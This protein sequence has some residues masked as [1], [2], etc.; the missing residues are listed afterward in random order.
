MKSIFLFT[1]A[2][3][4][5]LSLV[6]PVQSQTPIISAPSGWPVGGL[7]P[8]GVNAATGYSKPAAVWANNLN[9]Y[10][11]AYR[12]SLNEIIVTRVSPSGAVTGSFTAA[13]ARNYYSRGDPRVAYSTVYQDL[14]VVWE[15]VDP[16]T[17]YSNIRGSLDQ[18]G[19]SP[20]FQYSHLHRRAGR[21]M[22]PPFSGLFSG[23]G[24]VPG[25][26]AARVRPGSQREH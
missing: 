14:L 24:P 17:G 18:A 2:I 22:F 1:T 19:D 5:S 8:I 23:P 26:L 9:T 21:P 3:V 15:D 20:D 12:S 4:V 11:V 13:A 25:G 16:G 7:I 10:F 6:F